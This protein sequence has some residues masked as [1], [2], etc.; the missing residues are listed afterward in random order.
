MYQQGSCLIVKSFN[1][2]RM[3][4]NLKILEWERDLTEDESEKIKQIPPNQ[5]MPGYQFVNENGPGYK[6]V[7]ELWE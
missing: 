5:G 2:E 6:S 3:R 1:K 4:E 7:D